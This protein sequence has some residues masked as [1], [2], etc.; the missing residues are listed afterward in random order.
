MFLETER[1]LKRKMC[2]NSSIESA[3]KLIK[4]VFFRMVHI[5]PG[6]LLTIDRF[7]TEYYD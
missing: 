5:N 7:L 4:D 3:Y 2:I 1:R 6:L